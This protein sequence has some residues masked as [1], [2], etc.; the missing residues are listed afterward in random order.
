M[1]FYSFGLL[2][3]KERA[4]V[5]VIVTQVGCKAVNANVLP[6]VGKAYGDELPA[7]RVHLKR[8]FECARAEVFD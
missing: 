2:Q 5:G 6:A 1:G 3:V 7:F 8:L 4:K